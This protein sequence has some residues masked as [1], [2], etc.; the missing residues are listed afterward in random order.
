MTHQ[1]D[2]NLFQVQKLIIIEKLQTELQ[3]QMKH[4]MKKTII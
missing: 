1:R 4:A 3:V 2:K